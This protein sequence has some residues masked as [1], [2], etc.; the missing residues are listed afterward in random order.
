[1][2]HSISLV[3]TKPRICLQLN[4]MKKTHALFVFQGREH[5]YIY[6]TTAGIREGSGRGRGCHRSG[7]YCTGSTARTRGE[8]VSISYNIV[9]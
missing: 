9:T 6:P 7:R 1:M 8:K 4:L 2:Y 5:C 3:L